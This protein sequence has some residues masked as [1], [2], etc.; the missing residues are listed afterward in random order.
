MSERSV[1]EGNAGLPTFVGVVI[2]RRP[3]SALF[4][5]LT[6]L[7]TTFRPEGE[8]RVALRIL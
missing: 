2:G 8:T 1:D 3:S 7:C 4:L 6:F 5:V